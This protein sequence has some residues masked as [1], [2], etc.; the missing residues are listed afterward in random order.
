ML[1]E[2]LSVI[3]SIPGSFDFG[4]CPIREQTVKSFILRNP[5]RM[6]SVRWT[7][8]SKCP[9]E[10]KPD[11]GQLPANGKQEVTICYTPPEAN[12]LVATVIF[13]VDGE[14]EKVMKLSAIGKFSYITLNRN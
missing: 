9:F 1:D 13:R 4:F 6:R 14:G 3:D 8:S 2:P 10:V 5:N 12:V 11:R 7:V